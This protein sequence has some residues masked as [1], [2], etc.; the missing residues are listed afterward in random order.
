MLKFIEK[1][2]GSKHD[3][4][5]KR[6]WPIVDE[7]N[8]HFES[9]KS[10]SDE[11]LRGK[12][13]ELKEQIKE[14]IS[15]IEQSIIT[16]KKQLENLELTIE[17]A[18]SIQEKIEG[19]EKELH[20]ATEEALNEVLPEAFAIVKETAR[21]LVGKEYPVMGSTN[22]WNMVPYDVQLIGGIVLHQG[23]ISEMATGEGK[24]LVAVLPTFLNALTGKGVHIVTVNDYLAQRDKE[25]MT[26]IFEFHGL[27]VGAILGNMPPYQRKEQYACDITYGTNNEFGF[28]YL[29]D[30]MAGD[31]EDV[32]QREFNYAIIDEV[33]SVLIDEARTPLIISGPVP[34]ADVNKYNEIKPRVERLVRA[35]QNLVAKILTETE[36]AIKTPNKADKDAEFNIGLG[37][38]RAKRG[39]PKN[40]KFIK[41]I[42]EPNAARFMQTVENEFLKD[43]ARR[44]H[45]VDEELYFSIDEKN[46]TIELTEKGRE[47]MTDTHEDPD[48]FVL[49]DVGTEISKIDSDATLSEQDKVQKKDELYRLFSVRSERIHN[50][51]Q[52]LRAFS[53]YTRDDEYVVQ[54]GKVLI[55]DEFTG[56]IL[57][58]RRYSDGLHQALEAKEGVKIEGETQTMATIT[59]QNFF[60]LYKKLAGMTGTA[61]TE[62]SE[63]FEIYKLDVVVIPTNKPIVRK[64]QEDLIFKTKREKYNAVINKIQEL[65]EKGQPVLVGTT[66]VDVSETLSRMLK[67]KHIEHNV[68][69]AK[70]HAREAD[71]VAN[72]G[73][74]RAVTIATNMAGRGTDIKLGEGITEVGGLFILGTERHESRRI[75]RQ[76]RGR[77]GRQGDPGTSVFYVSLE[78]DLMR[79][80]GS[81]RVISVMDKLGH[82]EG[83]VIE[84]SMV[85]KSIERAQRRVE[86][87]NFAIR[88]R[89]L[90]YDNVMNQQREVIYTRRRKALEKRRLRIEIFDL[91]RDYAD[92]HAE[93]FYQALDKD[94]LEE[95]VLR[96]LS[97]DIKLTVDAF[98]KLGEDG[99][100]DK[101]YNTAVDFYKRKE[102]LLG[103]DIMAQ[104][105]KYSVLGVIDQ[106]WRE[107]LRDIDDLKEGINLRAYGQKDPLLEYKQEAFKLFVD[108]LEEISTETLSFAFKLFPQQAAERA[109]FIPERS[110]VRQERLVAQHEVA[111]SAYATAAP[112]AE[113]TTT[114]KAADAARQQPPAAE[115]EEQKRQPVHV[116]KTP[117]RNDP[118]PCGSGKKYKHCHGRNA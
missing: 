4:D 118:C 63:F 29:R 50:V 83:D 72:A 49:P 71:V 97:V 55:V 65:Q 82:Q 17:E 38:L 20:D 73:H 112:A 33:D 76:L 40:N 22:I 80:F 96:E 15:D 106:K 105:E 86:E 58:G 75:D 26:P 14:H 90:E 99:I 24:T 91:L 81:D 79:L 84:H 2:F 67:M 92:K 9:Y 3:R 13:Q 30:N 93:K 27:T 108:L 64:D 25:W 101:I 107:H 45:E 100:A 5:I 28:D 21:R 68:L 48:F 111:Q 88:K 104:I 37:L 116:E 69:N 8:E 39:Q 74:K 42:G 89:L 47:F 43:N 36:K 34:N 85:T 117:G 52:L 61:E 32:V 18:E 59:L 77:A 60:R 23:K 16:E 31:P 6:L 78:D 110:R 7:I 66:S 10:L 87:Q 19:I 95:Q 62:A 54:D 94:G 11:A 1:I 109:T 51:S 102:E 70:Q 115:N 46:H 98:E 53:L 41:L 113:T 44:M 103:N 12:T 114:A 56:R 35:Q 57:P